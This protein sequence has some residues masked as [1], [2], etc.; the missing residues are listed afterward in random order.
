MPA[1]VT[2]C[3]KAQSTCSNSS[4]FPL[5]MSLGVDRL[6]TSPWEMQPGPRNDFAIYML[7]KNGNTG[8]KFDK[9]D[10]NEAKGHD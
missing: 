6:I 8:A 7:K 3:R 2:V 9:N 1:E 4:S 10:T 5:I